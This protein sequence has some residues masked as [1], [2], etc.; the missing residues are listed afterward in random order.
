MIITFNTCFAR[1]MNSGRKALTKKIKMIRI[2]NYSGIH[3][4][5]DGFFKL[6][7]QDYDRYFKDELLNFY[8]K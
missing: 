5:F 7:M 2:S 3:V 6:R 1:T 8:E 4:A